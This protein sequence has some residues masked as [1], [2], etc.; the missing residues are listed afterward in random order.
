MIPQQQ[1]A[2]IIDEK[3][4][5]TPSSFAATVTAIAGNDFVGGVEELSDI[6]PGQAR[7]PYPYSAPA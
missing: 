3:N 7:T 4:S 2:T 6:F 5:F 1:S